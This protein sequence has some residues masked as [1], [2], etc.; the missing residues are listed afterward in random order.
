MAENNSFKREIILLIVG[1]AISTLT[2]ILT[3]VFNDIRQDKTANIEKRLELNDQI[4]KDLGKRL[5]FTYMIYRRRRDNDTTLKEAITN[6]RLSKEEWNLKFY[7]YQSLLKHYYSE[8]IKNEFVAT[9]YNPLVDLGQTVEFKKA[10]DSSFQ[11]KY[12]EQQS[13]NI[14]FIS[15]LYDLSNR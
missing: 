15:K 2:A 9:I 5:Y 3:N 8:E 1:A 13:K 12:V 10:M 11:K 14:E 7:S 4:S 6:Y